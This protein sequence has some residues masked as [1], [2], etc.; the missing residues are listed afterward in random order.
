M[1]K[2]SFVGE[3]DVPELLKLKKEDLETQLGQGII[4]FLKWQDPTYEVP[5]FNTADS[6]TT[7]SPGEREP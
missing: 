6:D 3:E 5:S 1:T 4:E 7:N 2:L